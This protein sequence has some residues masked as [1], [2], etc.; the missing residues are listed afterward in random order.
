MQQNPYY[1]VTIIK[2]AFSSQIYF[3]FWKLLWNLFEEQLKAF[4]TQYSESGT[5]PMSL[6]PTALQT[7]SPLSLWGRSTQKESE[8]ISTR[9]EQSLTVTKSYRINTAITWFMREKSWI[10]CF[11][12]L[13]Q[14]S[15]FPH[16]P[17][18]HFRTPFALLQG[19]WIVSEQVNVLCPCCFS[20]LQPIKAK[21]KN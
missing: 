3:E 16:E 2:Y 10:M 17:L 12:L 11:G 13:N 6:K 19:K 4:E 8:F 21:Q 14:I 18:F 20:F 15:F 5:V 7:L 9:E 1:G